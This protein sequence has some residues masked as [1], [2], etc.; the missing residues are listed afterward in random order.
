[1][2]ATFKIPAFICM[3]FLVSCKTYTM[4][5]EELYIQI[6]NATPV[7]VTT[8]LKG[9]VP[10]RKGQYLKGQAQQYISNGVKEIV[11]SDKHRNT[12]KISNSPRVEVRIIDTRNKIYDFYFDTINLEDSTFTG[13][14]L[15]GLATKKSIRYIDIAKIK[16]QKG[17]KKYIYT[18]GKRHVSPDSE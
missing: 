13:M 8:I 9:T 14:N 12:I 16:L 18:D 10:D 6:H 1:M 5:R 2:A 15:R 17:H 4:S 3:L 7:E 11:C